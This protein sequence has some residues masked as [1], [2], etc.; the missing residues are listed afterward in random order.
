MYWLI[1][2]KAQSELF[3]GIIRILAKQFDAASFAP[4]LTLC[5][6]GAGKSSAKELSKVRAGPIRLRIRGIPHS[7]KFTKTLFVRFTPTRSL[8]RLVTEL[9]GKPKSLTDPHL[10]LLYKK[11]PAAIRRELAAT[12]RLPIRQVAF[13]ALTAMSCVSPTKNK[14]DVKSWRKVAA[15]RLS[16]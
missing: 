3:R 16:G 2:N 13:D 6:A 5:R 4:H 15:K 14:Q 8:E 11:L 7:A 1:P 12:I 9:G 10:S